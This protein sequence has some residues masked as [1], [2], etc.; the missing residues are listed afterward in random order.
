MVAENGRGAHGGRW[1][2]IADCRL[3][4]SA[5]QLE[6]RIERRPKKF[7]KRVASVPGY[8]AVPICGAVSQLGSL[9]IL[10]TTRGFWVRILKLDSYCDLNAPSLSANREK[11]QPF[12]YFNLYAARRP[13]RTALRTRV[14][15]PEGLVITR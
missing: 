9:D 6:T 5:Q 14:T 3:L 12:L 8:T 15:V 13:D 7:K 11:S 10:Y 4:R 2:I 1:V